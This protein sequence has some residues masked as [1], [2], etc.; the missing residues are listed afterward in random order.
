MTYEVI[1]LSYDF[2]LDGKPI[3][4][5]PFVLD[6]T[7]GEP[8]KALNRYIRAECK[9]NDVEKTVKPKIKRIL[10][11]VNFLAEGVS[12]GLSAKKK[13]EYHESTEALIE[14]YQKHLEKRSYTG[15]S[16]NNY[17]RSAYSFLW[18]CE[19]NAS[20]RDCN[21]VIGITD[22]D[23]GIGK[24][25]VP[26]N[27]SSSKFQPYEIDPIY[28]FDTGGT[29]GKKKEQGDIRVDWDDAIEKA[30]AQGD[31]QGLRD[32]LI[33]RLARSVYLR[34]IAIANL[35]ISEFEEPVSEKD[36]KVGEKYVFVDED[37]FEK[38][39]Y[40]P[41][42]LM[43]YNDIRD[44][45][46]YIRPEF[47]VKGDDA[48]PYLFNGQKKGAH[49]SERQINNLLSKYGIKTHDGRRLGLTE[50]F[51]HYLDA[52]YSKEDC[53]KLV[54]ELANHSE[55]TS[56]K[57]LEESYLRARLIY[58]QNAYKPVSE[59]QLKVERQQK[60]IDELKGEL[61]HFKA[62]AVLK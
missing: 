13:Y 57:V 21:N 17:I 55:N 42:S 20:D 15:D 52:G 34:R 41:I 18:F 44:Y 14:E 43:L 37:K 22:A 8:H 40:S 7:T 12:F 35:K 11:Y 36:K 26:V 59:L 53:F 54:K 4:K 10:E 16:G 38:A 50:A 56:N 28:L 32:S 23:K 33:I 48:N 1:N 46:S 60:E 29:S 24:Y 3:P 58:E 31:E 45:I 6:S 2:E 39:H 47:L 27:T 61:A 19:H 5:M 30:E 51:I 9:S 49:L 25:P 62:K